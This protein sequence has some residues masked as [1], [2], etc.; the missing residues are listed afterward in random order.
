MEMN[1]EKW[2][3]KTEIAYKVGALLYSPAIY[4]DVVEKIAKSCDV[5]SV[6]FCLEDAIAEDALLQA[7]TT[8]KETL[9]T[10]KSNPYKNFP[11]IF[12][13]VR[14]PK[15]LQHVHQWNLGETDVIAGY[16]LPKFDLSNAEE[17]KALF[18]KINEN[19]A[20]PLYFMPILESGVIACKNTR[21]EQLY[22]IKAILDEVSQYVLNVRVGG[23]DFCNLF[24]L[25]RNVKQTIYDVGV[26]RDIL[27]D[28]LNVFAQDYV[29]SGPVWEYFGKD[30]DGEWLKGLKKELALDRLNGFI[31]KTCIHPQ[32]V[33]V[34]QE[35]LMVSKQDY[36]DALAILNWSEDELGVCASADHSRMNEVK[37]HVNWAKKI[38]ML[39]KIY[40][41]K[42][43]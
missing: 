24:G 23:N 34:V 38:S 2:L 6:A 10:I 18:F 4:K 27:I 30:E 31:G 36:Q 25:R 37:C 33:S 14:S 13:R 7:E 29:V 11:M 41:V 9:Q 8:L 21:Y 20:K 22:G 12:I 5:K 28:I 26:V 19:R 32:Q 17:Y 15:H 16:I 40:G 3:C 35:S 42:E 39:G 1:K 43:L